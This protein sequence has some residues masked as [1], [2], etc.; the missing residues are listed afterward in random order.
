MKFNVEIH[1][2]RQLLR[3]SINRLLSAHG[4]AGQLQARQGSL[5][6]VCG[7]SVFR[8]RQSRSLGHAEAVHEVQA[9]RVIRRTGLEPE[10]V[11]QGCELVCGHAR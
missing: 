7:A 6:S 4:L 11:R 8:A 9:H 3:H 2:L 10:K 1:F 5:Y